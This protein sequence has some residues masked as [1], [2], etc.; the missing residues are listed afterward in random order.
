MDA[1][2]GVDDEYQT[3]GWEDLLSTSSDDLKE[4]HFYWLHTVSKIVPIPKVLIL[5]DYDKRPPQT[6]RFSRNQVFLR[7][8]HTCQYCAKTLPKLRLNLDHVV[9]RIQGGKTTW[10]NVVTSCHPC[11]RRKGGRTPL[12]AGMRLL[13]HP[14][15]PGIS[16]MLMMMKQMNPAWSS[17]IL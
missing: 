4:T 5:Q 2:V 1:A 13:T 16:P 8:N 6:V 12:Q 10:E 11:N 3:Y 15:R 17:F 9:P 7:D 14:H